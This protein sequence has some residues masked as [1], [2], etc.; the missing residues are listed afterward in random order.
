[1]SDTNAI[2][3]QILSPTKLFLAAVKSIVELKFEE[4]IAEVKLMK[5]QECWDCKNYITV[6]DEKD[7]VYDLPYRSCSCEED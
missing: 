1:M 3:E 6:Y 5:Y 4:A 7:G 2:I